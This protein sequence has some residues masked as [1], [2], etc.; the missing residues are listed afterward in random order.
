[1]LFVTICK[2]AVR[3]CPFV[4][5]RIMPS[6]DT[7]CQY[8]GRSHTPFFTCSLERD[9]PAACDEVLFRQRAVPSI[10]AIIGRECSTKA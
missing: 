4:T 8:H 3:D 6:A 2:E 1:M 10:T 9:R 7:K 5:S